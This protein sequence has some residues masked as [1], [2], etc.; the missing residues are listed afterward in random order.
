MSDM[1]EKDEKYEKIVMALNQTICENLKSLL[2]ARNISQKKFCQQLAMEKTSVTRAYFN[3]ILQ[4]PKYISA[5]FLLSCCDFFGI[6]LQNLVSTHFNA[7]EYVYN[8]TKEHED[9]LEIKELL[10]KYTEKQEDLSERQGTEQGLE[11]HASLYAPEILQPIVSSDL[12]TDPSHNQFAGY[13]QEYFCYY[14]PTHSSESNED[15]ILKGVL[16]LKSENG[17]CKAVLTINTN[18]VDDE[19]NINY[20][21]YTGYAAVSTT[22]NSLNCVMYSESLCEFCFLMFRHFKLNFEKQDCRLAEVLSSSSA[23]E[24][25][26]PTVL[27]MLLSREEINDADLKVVAPSFL[28]NYSTIVVSKENLQKISKISED[29]REIVDAL[30]T[31]NEPM[32]VYF[33]KE[34]DVSNLASRYLKKKETV[35]E[36]LMQLRSASYAYRYNKVS[37]KADD[38]VRQILLSRGYYKKKKV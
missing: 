17:Y 31:N 20:K 4:N 11:L 7:E 8:E 27:R 21:T 34:D 19:G 24:D 12:I 13:L 10:Q 26:R 14:Y 38:A 6:T 25:R 1:R 15:D 30:F 9:Y 29:Y 5:A 3:K 35:L 37:L 22:V 33:Y 28:L 36:F 23:A 16:Q 2:E 32:P 18:T